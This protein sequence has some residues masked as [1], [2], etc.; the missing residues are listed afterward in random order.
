[1]NHI[2]DFFI[3][4]ND[5]LRLQKLYEYQILD[6]HPEDTFDK[7]AHLA[8]KIFKTPYAFVTFVDEDRVFI[9]ANV[10]P[11]EGN[12]VPREK[13]LCGMAIM[14]EDCTIIYDAL[15]NEQL[16]DSLLVKKKNGVRFYVGAPLRSPE[17]YL[18]GTVCVADK[19]PRTAKVSA[20]KQEMLKNL[21]DIV[22]NKLELRLRYKN[23]LKAQNELM[24]ITL[25]EIK[26]PL[27]S[28]KLAN[29]V[30]KKDPTRCD[31]MYNMVRE[32][33]TRIQ[34]KL[35]DL[36]KHSEEEEVQQKLSIE[37]TNLRE[38]FDSLLE[39]FQL[40]AN[41]KRQTI[42]LHYG[43]GIP[44][45]YIDRKKITDVFHNLLS[46]ALKYSY[47]DS[48]INISV[49]REKDTVEIEFHDNGQGLNQEDISKL[50]TKFAKLS[51][52]PTGKETSNGLGLSICKTM[53]EMHHGKIHATSPGKEMGTSFFVSLPLIYEVENEPF[54]P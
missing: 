30:I 5:S 54:L 15:E 20:K 9:K 22:V 46:N 43:S 47:Y 48:E 28:I 52:K 10:S 17:G 13:S 27:A 36:L 45:V 29:D 21:A 16:K 2:A 26:N 24:N 51:A 3:P 7:I 33:V 32:S 14:D 18:L 50:F 40:Q 25:H 41:K 1:M 19:K 39:S 44:P 53:V 31:S 11:F 38:I 35:S 4:E 49:K 42:F 8:A 6:T 37:E 12:V 23:L 34:T